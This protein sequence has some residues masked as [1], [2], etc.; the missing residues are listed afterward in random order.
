M[1]LSIFL[2]SKDRTPFLCDCSLGDYT[3]QQVVSTFIFQMGTH[4]P[5]P[6][7]HFLS[8]ALSAV[9]AFDQ[10]GEHWLSPGVTR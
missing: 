1:F 10:V 3:H 9:I 5:I 6:E 8:L 4:T 7:L 2:P